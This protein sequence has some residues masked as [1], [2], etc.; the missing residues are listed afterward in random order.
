MVFEEFEKRS[1]VKLGTN[2]LDA[3][4]KSDI[5]IS[6]VCGGRGLCGKCRV[7]VRAGSQNLGPVY[8]LEEMSLTR[9]ELVAGYRLACC[10][11]VNREG[12][13]FVD[14]PTES[15]I[16]QQRLLVAG[17]NVR[18]AR[19][20]SVKKLLVHLSEPTLE[21]AKSD[22]ESLQDGLRRTGHPSVTID[23]DALT[24]LPSAIRKGQ[25]V[26][27]ACL[28]GN[29]E[30]IH[31]DPGD[32]TDRAFALA[33][34]VG[35]TKIATYLLDLN[36]GKVVSTA[37]A[38][39]P[40]IRYGED[41]ISRISYAS[42]DEK[43]LSEIQGIL[44]AC[45]N[46]L[47]VDVCNNGSVSSS[48]VYDAVIVGN[49]VM[50][51]LLLGITPRFVGQSPFA[52]AVR[53]PVTIRAK[54]VGL[55]ISSAANVYV[56][57]NVAGF[58]GSDTVADV[59]ATEISKSKSLSLMIDVG[60]N[61]EIILGNS[62]SMISCSCASGPAL[63]GGHIEYGTRA[64]PGAIENVYIDPRTLEPWLKT[65]GDA[66]PRGICG[67]GIV[68]V[69]AGMLRAGIINRQGLINTGLKTPRIRSE[70]GARYV[71]SLKQDNDL[72]RDIVVTQRD[73]Q[74]V[75]LA[76]AAIYSGTAV[77][78]KR[79]GVITSEIERVF[80]AGAFGTYV[81]PHSAMIV[82]MYPDVPLQ[83]VH[84]VGNAAGSGARMMLLSREVRR[85]A[86]RIAQQ[87]QY[88]ELASDASF[89]REFTEALELP[90][91]DASRFPNITQ[92]IPGK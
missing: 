50:H 10:A 27:T 16:L 79:F 56:P 45:I 53:S 92:L 29:Q 82:G 90:H 67:S 70:G 83:R 80:L 59:L 7:I 55:K 42:K 87:I 63:E 6:A 71:L 28:R 58:V 89:Q 75:Q 85:D 41:I 88:V 9:D 15:R 25:W 68:D 40:Q 48:E 24:R 61:T 23:F 1:C 26:I 5:C 84:F 34:D 46:N 21:K 51:H 74:E 44:I 65:V 91:N 78:M 19:D 60:T 43:S 12:S 49:T 20:P 17:I 62:E 47:L 3:I 30:V 2:I 72:D 86:E 54:D 81:D 36:T 69:V 13:T 35:T 73:V 32:T 38:P 37:A 8:P 4:K 66:R 39:N 64:E 22:D 77:L 57:P 52:P 76:K 18:V 11:I 31:V 33:V 14:V